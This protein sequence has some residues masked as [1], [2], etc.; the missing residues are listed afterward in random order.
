MNVILELAENT[1]AAQVAEMSRRVIE[2]GLPWTWTA[3]R[4]ARHIRHS[5][6]VV[7]V[8]RAEGC[9]IG[10][11]IMIFGNDRAHL[12]LLAVEPRYQGRGV[13]QAL[14]RWLEE[15]AAVA[16]TFVIHVE[17]RARNERARQ[18]YSRLGYAEK[19]RACFYY[20]GIEDAI[21]V[22]RDLRVFR[23]HQ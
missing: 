13:G 15:S 8:A 9:L 2:Y 12:N 6:S 19:G 21:R 17:V 3:P 14:V 18:F 7:L 16:G 10:F 1:D 5:E 22:T 11:A 4:V 23:H 20:G